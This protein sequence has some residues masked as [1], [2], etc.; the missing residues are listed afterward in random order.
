MSASAEDLV[1]AAVYQHESYGSFGM[2]QR[3]AQL[4]EAELLSWADC[5][6]EAGCE[7]TWTKVDLGGGR[8]G[9]L[10]EGPEATSV[11]WLD[12]KVRFDVVGP[13]V[14]FA[15]QAALDVASSVASVAS[16]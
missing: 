10:I 5:D 9:I 11:V 3:T 1:F 4:A 15:K 6:P 2:L 14:T 13:S 16:E 12:G 7:G 8:A